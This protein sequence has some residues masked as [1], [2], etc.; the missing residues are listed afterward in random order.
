[1]A[2]ICTNLFYCH[3]DN[4]ENLK[5][6]QKFLDDAFDWEYYSKE[7]RSLQGEFDSQWTFPEIAFDKM[8]STLQPDDSLYIRVLSY[9]FG[10]EYAGYRIFKNNHWKIYM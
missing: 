3:T 6:I 2:N 5:T 9:E 10:L 8:M 1:M 7:D 4:A